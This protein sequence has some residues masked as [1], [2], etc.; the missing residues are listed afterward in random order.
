M[1]KVKGIYKENAVR[2]L[3]PVAATN[4]VEVDV[5][6]HDNVDKD[7]TFVTA[8]KQELERMENGLKLG[9]GPYYRSREELHER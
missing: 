9:G 7:Q 5:I 1:T 8:M 6:F 4:G 2:L 3:E